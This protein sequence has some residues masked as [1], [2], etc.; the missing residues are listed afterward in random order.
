[1]DKYYILTFSRDE[2]KYWEERKGRKL[3]TITN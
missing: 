1:M 2:K 3:K